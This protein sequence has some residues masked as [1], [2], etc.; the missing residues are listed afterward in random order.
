MKQVLHSHH[1]RIVIESLGSTTVQSKSVACLARSLLEN[2]ETLH[3]EQDMPTEL[4]RAAFTAELHRW[5]KTNK[6]EK[7]DA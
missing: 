3:R 1:F 6:A 4:E 7:Q 5:L 2:L